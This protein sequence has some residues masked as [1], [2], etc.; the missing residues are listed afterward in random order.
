ML[1]PGLEVYGLCSLES[2]I[3]RHIWYSVEV[4]F[5]GLRMR[6]NACKNTIS[7][8]HGLEYHHVICLV[9]NLRLTR[10]LYKVR[11]PVDVWCKTRHVDCNSLCKPK[12][13]T[14][15]ML[16]E[17]NCVDTE[18]SCWRCSLQVCLVSWEPL[19]VARPWG[20]PREGPQTPRGSGVLKALYWSL[21]KTSCRST[22]APPR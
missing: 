12:A 7:P 14:C 15:S 22:L 3:K 19:L 9:L 2:G 16:W 4:A 11:F 5:L 8:V 20:L 6:S 10:K 18:L 21:K 1:L 13:S 17:W